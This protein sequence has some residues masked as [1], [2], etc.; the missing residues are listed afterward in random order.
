M[1]YTKAYNT[2]IDYNSKH[3]H[4]THCTSEQLK[5]RLSEVLF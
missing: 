2:Y 1:G 3:K 5:T 4:L